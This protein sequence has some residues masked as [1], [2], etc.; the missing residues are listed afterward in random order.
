MVG[1]GLLETLPADLRKH[2][3]AARYALVTDDGVDAAWG[4]AVRAAFAAAELS[5]LVKVVPAGETYKTRAT[6]ESIEDWYDAWVG[7]KGRG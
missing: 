1:R 5:L 6:K 4:A 2:V 7:R 3:P